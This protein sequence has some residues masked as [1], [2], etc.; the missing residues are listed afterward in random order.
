MTA[1]CAGKTVR[2]LENARHTSALEVCSRRCAIRIHVYLYLLP[3]YNTFRQ[4]QMQPR[5]GSSCWSL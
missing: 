1:G 2:S 5:F 4:G 3:F